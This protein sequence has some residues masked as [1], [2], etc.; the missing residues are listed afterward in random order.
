MGVDRWLSM[1]AV[2]Q[3]EPLPFAVLMFGT[4]I[5][6]DFV[7]GGQHQGGWIVPGRD[8]MQN[9]LTKNTAR[10]FCEQKGASQFGIGQSTPN[11]VSFGCFAA[12]RGVIQSA[13]EWLQQNWSQYRI[14]VTGG[15]VNIISSVEQGDIINA[16]NLVLQGLAHYAKRNKCDG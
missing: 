7:R 13:R 15:D 10:V 3:V 1:V 6:C 11:C 14:Y 12:A 8:L 4:A 5:T 16:E 9:A 2:H